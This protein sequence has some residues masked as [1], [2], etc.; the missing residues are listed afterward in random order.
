MRMQLAQ[1]YFG[2]VRGKAGVKLGHTQQGG[3][4]EA[5]ASTIQ[6]LMD[7]GLIPATAVSTAVR[8]ELSGSK[9]LSAA[10]LGAVFEGIELGLSRVCDLFPAT[11]SDSLKVRREKRVLSRFFGL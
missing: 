7:D 4:I 5:S 11:E 3:Y 6:G 10:E 9:E 8:N 1:K 2:S